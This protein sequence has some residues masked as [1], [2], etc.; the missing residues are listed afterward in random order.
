MSGP[1]ALAMVLFFRLVAA[2]FP[3]A[4]S[5]LDKQLRGREIKESVQ[6]RKTQNTKALRLSR[7]LQKTQTYFYTTTSA[8]K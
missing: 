7:G 3:E 6:S 1:T 8:M 2:T 5:V 4:Q